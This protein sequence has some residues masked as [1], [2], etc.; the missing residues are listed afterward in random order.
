MSGYSIVLGPC[1]NCGQLF[2]F[3][4]HHVPSITIKGQREP[5]CRSCFTR[6]QE[7]HPDVPYT[8]HPE[9]Y[10]PMEGMP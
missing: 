1:V 7:M 2:G 6:W 10:D 5:L 4:P 9:A 3:N 8:L